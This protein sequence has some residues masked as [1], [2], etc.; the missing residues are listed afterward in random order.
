ML[1]KRIS[2]LV[3]IGLSLHFCNAIGQN[4]VDIAKTNS[5]GLDLSDLVYQSL[6]GKTYADS[7]IWINYKT[8]VSP[9]EPALSITAE[10]ASGQ[11]PE[12]FE[13]FIEVRTL[14]G[15][16]IGKYGKPTGK[17]PLS[18]MPRVVIQDM[19]NSDTGRGVF[20]G[21]QVI[22]SFEIVDFS[23]IQPGETSLYIQF[24]LNNK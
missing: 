8:T 24:T 9:S 1:N 18:H 6:R 2:L 5:F 23:L 3:L 16:S 17:V 10:I 13:M 12:G 4:R 15:L 20:M 22:V 11:V 19:G 14:K 7:S 21:H